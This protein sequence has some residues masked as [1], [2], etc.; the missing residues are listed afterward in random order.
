MFE[1]INTLLPILFLGNFE[2]YSEESLFTHRAGLPPAGS[3]FYAADEREKRAEK[4]NK[5]VKILRIVSKATVD[6]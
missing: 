5:H 1:S 3:A 4:V 2:L 6:S